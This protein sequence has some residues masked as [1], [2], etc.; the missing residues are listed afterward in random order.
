[1][2]KSNNVQP[3]QDW[4][5]TVLNKPAAPKPQFNV[6]PEVKKIKQL[7]D[8]SDDKTMHIETISVNYQKEIIKLR[9][10]NKLSQEAL[11]V[12]LGL[13]KYTIKRIENGTHP[14][15]NQLFSR[16]KQHLINKP[17]K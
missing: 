12:E 5:T 8:N 16:I 3:H 17:I 6:N 14:K 15:N 11:D 7:E 9:L 1:M 10:S 4:V 13:P 2:S